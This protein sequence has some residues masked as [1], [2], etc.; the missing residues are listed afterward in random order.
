MNDPKSFP[1]MSDQPTN[2]GYGDNWD[3]DD[4]RL[5]FPRY[6]DEEDIEG[7]EDSEIDPNTEQG[8]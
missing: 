6:P 4:V 5:A 7:E 8:F 3:W 2:N 1:D